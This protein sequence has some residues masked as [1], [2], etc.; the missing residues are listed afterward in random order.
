LFVW[1]PEHS[2]SAYFLPWTES[3]ETEAEEKA[4]DGEATQNADESTSGKTEDLAA[5]QHAAEEIQAFVAGVQQQEQTARDETETRASTEVAAAEA[6][7]E[8]EK[9]EATR[10]VEKDDQTKRIGFFGFFAMLFE[11]FCSPANKKKD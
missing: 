1:G 11:R 7:A 8:G 5:I 6:S 10:E 2:T 3:K 9:P 4:K